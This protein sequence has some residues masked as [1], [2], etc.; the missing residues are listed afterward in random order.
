MTKLS[1]SCVLRSL[2]VRGIKKIQILAVTK[3]INE[4]ISNLPALSSLDMSGCAGINDTILARALLKDDVSLTVD[5]LVELNLSLCKGLTDAS[6]RV[7]VM[8]CPNLEVLDLG[9]CTGIT[10]TSL[11]VLASLK[12]LRSLNLRSCWQV[13]D[14][15]VMHLSSSA[16]SLQQLNLQDCQKVSDTALRHLSHSL[17][18]KPGLSQLNLS[19]CANVSDSGMKS[20]SKISSLRSLNLRSCDNIT[21]IG[22]GYLAEASVGLTTLDLSFCDKVSD[23]ALDHIASGLF[24]L[25]H[26]SLISCRIT[27][28]GLGKICKTLADLHVL[29]IG[30][31]SALT[32]SALEHIGLRL[33][34]MEFLDLYGCNRISSEGLATLESRCPNLKKI[35][36]NLWHSQ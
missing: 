24:N 4:L 35:N 20:L 5:S 12:K 18:S 9:G 22:V 36:L 25:T 7:I 8:K 6:S 16:E 19:F 28:E 29:N 27:D 14:S 21:D 23:R 15:G 26:L 17:I 13:S 1:T 2:K 32:D 3:S 33:K 10:N 31:C 34:R 30:Q 11:S